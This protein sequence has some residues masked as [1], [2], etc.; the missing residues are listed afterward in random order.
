MHFTDKS[1]KALK[2]KEN[3]FVATAKSAARDV[4]RLQLK[5]YPTGTKKFQF[6]YYTNGRRRIEIGPNG[7]LSLRMPERNF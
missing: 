5:V 2:P 6:Q 3:L 4:G 7:A 1:I